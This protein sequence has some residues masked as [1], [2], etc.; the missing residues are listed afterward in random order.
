MSKEKASLASIADFSILII[1]ASI[2]DFK[3]I[4]Q[5]S[6]SWQILSLVLSLSSIV[7][8]LRCRPVSVL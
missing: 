7:L 1:D 4:G 3:Y 8:F 5:M 6:G 2:W